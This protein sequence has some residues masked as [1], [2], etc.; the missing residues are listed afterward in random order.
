MQLMHKYE[1]LGFYN[2]IFISVILSGIMMFVKTDTI[3]LS[4]LLPVNDSL[5]E[6][7]KMLFISILI[8]SFIEYYIF[9]KRFPNFFFSKLITL[10]VTP[11][12]YVYVTYG[13]DVIT[14]NPI[15][16]SHFF[17]FAISILLGQYLSYVMLERKYAFPFM[18]VFAVIS[19]LLLY[20]F[21][22]SFSISNKGLTAPYHRSMNEYSRYILKQK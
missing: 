17:T 21:Y 1:Y 8:Y 2:I 9:G 10:I 14:G 19:I 11:L 15:A 6:T 7:G 12:F 3:L 20:G 4:A 18:N 13:I 16:I 5:F 22:A